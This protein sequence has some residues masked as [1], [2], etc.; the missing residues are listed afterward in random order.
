MVD[1]AIH[2]EGSLDHSFVLQSADGHC[3]VMNRAEAFAVAGESMVK[4]AA[5]IE[6][7]PVREGVASGQNGP[8]RRQPEGGYHFRRIGDFEFRQFFI[9]QCSEF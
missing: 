9:A 2:H 7:D 8:S 1:V 4:S 6:T 5:D 3:Y